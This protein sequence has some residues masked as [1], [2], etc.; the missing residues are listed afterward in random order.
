MRYANQKEAVIDKP[1]VKGIQHM[2]L[3]FVTLSMALKKLRTTSG[4]NLYFY[5]ARH[6]PAYN[7]SYSPA[8]IEE[9]TGMSK[10][11]ITKAKKELID[12]GFIEETD[13][14]IIFHARSIFD[15]LPQETIVSDEKQTEKM[16][17]F[18]QETNNFPQETNNFPQETNNF[19]QETNNFPQETI[20]SHSTEEIDNNN[21]NNKI[22]SLEPAIILSER[23]EKL[24]QQFTFMGARDSIQQLLNKEKKEEEWIVAAINNKGISYFNKYGTLGLLFTNS[25]QKEIDGLLFKKKREAAEREYWRKAMFEQGSQNLVKQ[26]TVI[27]V[28]KNSSISKLKNNR[29]R[30]P[31]DLNEIAKMA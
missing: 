2:G 7:F 23:L 5:L 16:E 10:S 29:Q 15:S 4:Y 28:A 11:S 1:D 18:P 14:K 20:V 8:H 22:D 3:D 13:S 17:R 24:V 27:N 12:L 9:F 21:N 30:P 19:P 6:K 31:Y 25:Y 26:P